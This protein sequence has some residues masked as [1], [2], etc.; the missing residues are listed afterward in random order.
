MSRPNLR[1]PG[2]PEAPRRLPGRFKGG[3]SIF[4]RH[5][6]GRLD[7]R[8]TASRSGSQYRGGR[9]LLIREL[10]N[11]QPIMVAEGQV[12]PDEP[13]SDTLEELGDGF[14]TIFRLGQHAFDS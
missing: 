2:A 11:G 9:R 13:A 3:C 14:L 5:S 6:D 4:R 1:A 8:Q 12:P 10:A 7:F